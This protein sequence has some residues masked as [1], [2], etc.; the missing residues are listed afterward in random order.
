MIIHL[1]IDYFQSRNTPT[2][3][4]FTLRHAL[5]LS[6]VIQQHSP[7]FLKQIDLGEE[8]GPRTVVSGLVHY[9]P[10]EQMKDKYLIAVVRA[11]FPIYLL[12]VLLVPAQCNLKP[13]AMRGIKSYG[14]VLAV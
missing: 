10:I 9:I 6:E 14:M 13:A 8:T 1:N 12:I 4:V 11:I 7:F 5:H 2:P 3:M